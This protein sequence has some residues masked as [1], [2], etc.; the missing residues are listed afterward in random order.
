M[1]SSNPVL[2]VEDDPVNVMAVGKAFRNLEIA[3]SLVHAR[4]GEEAIS[5]YRENVYDVVILDLTIPGGMGGKEA[6][7]NLLEIDP[8]VK[9]IV[10]SGYSTDPLMS[11]FEQYGF[12][13]VMAKP[14]QIE[15]LSRMVSKIIGMPP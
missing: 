7:K 12:K 14:Y 4:N 3:Q 15:E 9:A 2:L 11:E 10:S 1:Q 13:G 8:N 5:L 6:I